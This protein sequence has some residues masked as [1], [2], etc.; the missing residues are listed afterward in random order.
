MVRIN[1]LLGPALLCCALRLGAQSQ[2]ELST[3]LE[4]LDRLER[5]NRVLTDR[6]QT[7]QARLDAIGTAK[8]AP[9][10]NAASAETVPGA[11][12]ASNVITPATLEQQ[13]EIQGKRIDE[14]AQTKVEASQRFPIRLTGMALFNAYM[15]SRQSGGAEYPVVAAAT[16]P[17]SAGATLRQTI[18]GLD[19][20]GPSTVWGGTVHG[21]VYMDFAA[22]ATNIA[23]RL[24]TGS[25]E[26]DWK[27]RSFMVGLEKP[28][29]NPREP[30]SLAQ[31]AVSPLTGVG[32]LWLWVPQ[33]RFEQDIAFTRSTGIRAQGG[34]VQTHE[35]GPYAGSTFTG[36]VESARPGGEGRVELYHNLDDQR[37]LEFASGFHTSQTHVIG[38]SVESQILSLD[39]FFNPLRKV[40]FTGAFYTGQNVA[41]L[42]AGYQQ[43]FGVYYSH[44]SPVHSQ[45]GWAQI[46]FHAAPRL[47]FHFF[48]G[49]QDDRNSDLDRGGIGKNLLF[50][51]N[52]YFHLAPN[53]LLGLETTQLRTTYLGQGIRIN[54]HYD[55]ALGYLF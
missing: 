36:T 15:N 43:G 32:N 16:G 48:T 47:D 8:P 34:V 33:A 26:I 30:S 21:S 29:F 12:G 13:V 49:Q 3:I 25:I 50:G 37:R 52:V 1:R 54:N 4:R 39:W 14:Q 6:V 19:F 18:V 46:T 40:D 22:G 45:G 23:M 38:K 27:N 17:A 51:G 2:P 20:R 44:V 10:E 42:G 55:L 9:A 11:D 41:P 7:L 5:E 35:I 53:V 31:L 28:I 24:R